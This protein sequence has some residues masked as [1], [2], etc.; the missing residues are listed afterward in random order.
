[1]S[2]TGSGGTN[3]VDNQYLIL[4]ELFRELADKEFLA[5]HRDSI[6][7][8]L[9]QALNDIRFMK[10]AWQTL[11]FEDKLAEIVKNAKWINDKDHDYIAS[12]QVPSLFEVLKQHKRIHLGEYTYY[13][14]SNARWIYRYPRRKPQPAPQTAP[15]APQGGERK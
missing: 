2:A 4:S 11:A 5:S 1:M 10:E 7:K 15:Q 12:E 14:S 6:V 13:L 8:V 9:Q 3:K